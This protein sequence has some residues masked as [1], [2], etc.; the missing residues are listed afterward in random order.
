MQKVIE[1]KMTQLE[2]CEVEKR[3]KLLQKALCTEQERFKAIPSSS[4]SRSEVIS[5][6]I[7]NYCLEMVYELNRLLST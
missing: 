5:S 4:K 3:M 7:T 2:H 6:N 1:Y